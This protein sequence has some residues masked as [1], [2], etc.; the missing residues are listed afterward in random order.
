MREKKVN[1]QTAEN[2][3]NEFADFHINKIR[4]QYEYLIWNRK[5]N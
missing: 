3:E 4:F 2:E 1:S 5:C